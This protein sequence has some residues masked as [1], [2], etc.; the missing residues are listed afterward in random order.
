MRAEV[1]FSADTSPMIAEVPSPASTE[2]CETLSEAQRSDFWFKDGNVILMAGNVAFKVHRGNL[3]RHSEIFRDMLS[4]P[5]PPDAETFEDCPLIELH[6]SPMD[7]WHL[8]RAIYDGLYVLIIYPLLSFANGAGKDTS[9]SCPP[10]T[11]GLYHLF[12]GYLLNTSSTICESAASID[13]QSTGLRPWVLGTHANSRPQMCSV[14]TT[15]ERGSPI[16][17]SSS[18][19]LVKCKLITSYLALSTISADTVLRR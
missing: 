13:Y 19:S 14:G 18:T 12:S 7:L 9:S 16:R 17:S 15:P 1:V 2:T 4:I 5:Q 8:L 11:S 10:L 6:D 3:E